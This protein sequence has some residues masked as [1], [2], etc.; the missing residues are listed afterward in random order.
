MS[1]MSEMLRDMRAGAGVCVAGAPYACSQH[2]VCVNAG[3]AVNVHTH[4][5][6]R[7][8]AHTHTHTHT[9]AHTSTQ[10]HKHTH[11][12]EATTCPPGRRQRP[13]ATTSVTA[14]IGSCH[15]VMNIHTHIHGS[16]R[17]LSRGDIYICLYTCIH[18]H[19]HG[20]HRQLSRGDRREAVAF[21]VCLYI[22]RCV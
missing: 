17:Q 16:H 3:Q 15:A 14:A 21:V 11:T 2:V 18:T 20:S 12:Q 5:H 10:A 19:I 13:A 8:H 7:T 4:T 1:A 22:L 6:T 9:H